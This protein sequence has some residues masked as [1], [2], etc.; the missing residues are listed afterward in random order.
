[1]TKDLS[2]Q[3]AL[4]TGGAKG[5]GLAIARILSQVGAQVSIVGRDA[6]ALEAAVASGAAHHFAPVDIRDETASL[7]A[8]ARLADTQ[9]FDI[10]VANAGG[11]DTA[12]FQKCDAAFFT[13]MLELNL[14]ST[15]TTFRAVL[16]GMVNRRRG[17][18]IAVAST[19]G[20]R[21]YAYVS[22]YCAAKHAV[23]GLVKSLALETARSGV[24]VNAIC[25]G[26]TDTDLVAASVQRIADRT[27][28][29]VDDAMAHLVA[30]NPMGRLI[31]PDEVA[32]AALYLCGPLAGATT[33]QS[34]IVNGGEF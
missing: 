32:A 34:I 8:I 15:V 25:P 19:A 27:A 22:A 12:P 18:L 5:I 17:R 3:H 10:A 20:H 1:M 30:D 11:V 23:L 14:I 4:V 26:Y 29:S 16:P 33:G 21:G 24:T 13:A 6:K 28:V 7:A 9:P 31:R 2:G